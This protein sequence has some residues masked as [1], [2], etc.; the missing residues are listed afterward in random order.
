MYSQAMF[1]PE[2]A[3]FQLYYGAV[4]LSFLGG[5]RWGMAATSYG[6][7]HTWAQYSWS[8]TPS[9]I[10]WVALMLPG[11]TYGYLSLI[12][13]HG[14]TFYKDMNESGYP[15]WFKGLRFF[16]TFFALLSLISGLVCAYA[17]ANKKTLG[18]A[19]RDIKLPKPEAKA[20]E[21][22]VEAKAKEHQDKA[23]TKEE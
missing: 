19:I 20:N 23:E 5:V 4:I 12:I 17:F 16:L 8:V 11:C 22:K 3:E 13:G 21:L 9:L 2:L 10:A 7:P 1:C 18:E 15:S 14:I 6:I